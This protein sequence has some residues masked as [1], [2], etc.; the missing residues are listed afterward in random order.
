[1]IDAVVVADQRVGDAAQLQQAIPICVVPRQTGNFQSQDDAHMSQRH[2][3]GEASKPGALVG[4]GA[5]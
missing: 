1:M 2:F 5:G 3:A 4:S